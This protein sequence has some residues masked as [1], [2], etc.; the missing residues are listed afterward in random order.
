MTTR[1]SQVAAHKINDQHND[2]DAITIPDYNRELGEQWKNTLSDLK[3][4]GSI[5]SYGPYAS[6]ASIKEDT[7]IGGIGN[8]MTKFANSL[9]AAAA[10]FGSGGMFGNMS[11]SIGS[12]IKSTRRGGATESVDKRGLIRQLIGLIKGIITLPMRFANM[13][14]ALTNSGLALALGAKGLGESTVLGIKDMFLLF[15]AIFKLCIKYGACMVSF[16]LT[17]VFGGCFIPHIITFLFYVLYLIFPIASFLV[18]SAS[19]F[20][21]DPY[22]DSMF[23][24]IHLQDEALVEAGTMPFH[25]TKWPEW[26]NML[27]YRCFFKEVHLKDVLRDVMVVKHIGD[28][29]T[30]DFNVTVPR[31]MRPARGVAVSAKQHLDAA[32][33]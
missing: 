22:I 5:P 33:E 16:T 9:D 31:Y 24:M 25:V 11:Y 32:I 29:I 15:V 4:A 18:Y 10:G 28:L 6:S 20:D 21:L 7:N 23:E 13:F 30:H 26:I 8:E 12:G 2:N 14:Q 19:G 1:K 17:T 27:C 3:T